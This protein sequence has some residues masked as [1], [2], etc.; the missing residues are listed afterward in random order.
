MDGGGIPVNS[1][2]L[3]SQFLI[4]AEQAERRVGFDMSGQISNFTFIGCVTLVKPLNFSEPIL[5][6]PTHPINGA[7]YTL[8]LMIMAS[9]VP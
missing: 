4:G 8:Y 2:C 3:V 1:F 6:P 9:T 7:H 5:P